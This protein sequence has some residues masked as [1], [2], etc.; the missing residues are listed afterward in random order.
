MLPGSYP[1][2]G[3]YGLKHHIVE[4]SEGV[5]YA[6]RTND[7]QTNGVGATQLLKRKAEFCFLTDYWR[8]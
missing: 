4:I 5:T 3:L 2:Y 7:E 1:I 8:F 6:G